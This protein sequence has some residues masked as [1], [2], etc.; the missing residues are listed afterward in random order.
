MRIRCVHFIFQLRNIKLKG[1]EGDDHDDEEMVGEE[2]ESLFGRTSNKEAASARVFLDD[3]GTLHW[4]ILLLYPEYG[5][6][7]FITQANETTRCVNGIVFKSYV[8]LKTK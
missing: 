2:W 8:S 7:D 1:V 3:F 4:P 6:T 5:Q